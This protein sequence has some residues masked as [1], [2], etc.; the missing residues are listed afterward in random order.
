VL[1]V[2]A[3]PSPLD[4][5]D[6][7]AG[8]WHGATH[9]LG[10]GAD[11]YR[12]LVDAERGVFLRAEALL[13]GAPFRVLEMR[14]LAFDEDLPEHTFSPPEAVAVER[15][16]ASRMVSLADL[17][18]AVPFVVLVP[19]RP[20]F[21]P[22]HV[23]IEPPRPR[24]GLP[25]QVHID[26]LSPLP[27]EERRQFFLIESADPIPERAWVDWREEDGIRLGEDPQAQPVLRLARLERYGTHVEI[28]SYSLSVEELRDLA[29]SL[30]PLPAE[31]PT[32]S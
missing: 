31:P 28:Q 4:E 3:K 30:V 7:E 15:V 13:G 26:Y 32:L 1:E 2:V 24:H 11:E 8:D 5:D 22:P 10:S 27:G 9:G 19:A 29:R 6:E 16:E 20:P 12:L 17:P 23:F 25:T 14:D 18:G 21:G